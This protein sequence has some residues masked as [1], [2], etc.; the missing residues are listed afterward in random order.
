VLLILPVP[1]L[2]APYVSSDPVHWA[3]RVYHPFFYRY[4]L[5]TSHLLTTEGR[6]RSA[7]SLQ[8]LALMIELY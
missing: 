7:Q 4:P 8:I 2:I 1:A 6:P 5:Y 3:Y